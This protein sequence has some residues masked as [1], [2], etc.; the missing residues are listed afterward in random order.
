MI[1]DGI[2]SL[3]LQKKESTQNLDEVNLINTP[4]LYQPFKCTLFALSKSA[5]FKGIQTLKDKEANRE[6][7]TNSE[8]RKLNISF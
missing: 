2:N 5:K 8:L 7:T 4:D 1:Q 3:I 6:L